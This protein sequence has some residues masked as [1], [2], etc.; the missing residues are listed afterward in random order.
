MIIGVIST[1]FSSLGI[2]GF[3]TDN[4]FLLYLGMIFVILEHC[5]GI[6]SG[7]EKGLTTVWMALLISFGMT[8]GGMNLLQA[9]ALCLCF[10]GTICFILG[11]IV[12]FSSGT[13]NQS[14][15]DIDNNNKEK[16]IQDLMT[17]SGLSEQICTDVFEILVCFAYNDKELAYS[18]INNQLVPHLRETQDIGS[19]GVAFGMLINE[20]A[21]TQE[22][23][24]QYSSKLIEELII[25]E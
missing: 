14:K 5:I 11:L 20:K 1:I 10:E 6:L 16:I 23:S 17:K 24:T 25:N 15:Q 4:L 8:A 19:I 22:E 3:F 12:M 7:Q 21:L 18:K 2:Y 13:Y 9:I